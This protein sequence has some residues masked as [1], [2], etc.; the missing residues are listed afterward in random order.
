IA[1]LAGSISGIIS[2]AGL[3]LLL[4][5]SKEVVIS[6]APKSVT[7]PI[8]MGICEKLGGIPSLTAGIVVATGI[9]G[10]VIGHL[11]LKFIR[12]TSPTAFGLAMGAASHG[13]GTARAF[14][15]GN[16][17]GAMSGLAMCMNG[18]FTAVLTPL[19]LKFV[20]RII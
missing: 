13:I 20:F 1:L 19:I 17:Q 7:A 3:A 10:A 2:A 14:E 6:L 11:F 18:V 12:V 5:A 15:E 8:A 4:N 16:A 9:L